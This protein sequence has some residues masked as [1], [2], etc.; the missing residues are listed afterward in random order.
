[1]MMSKKISL[2]IQ[3]LIRNKRVRVFAIINTILTI[4]NL[5][6][7]IG[8]MVIL[9]FL[10]FEAV[11]VSKRS[12]QD[13]PCIF[14]WTEWSPC[15]A[16]CATSDKPPMKT[17]SVNQSSIIQARGSIYKPCPKDLASR[18][19]FAPCN[20]HRCPIK[21]SSI[22]EWTQ[23]FREDVT[24]QNTKCYQM[25]NLTIGDYLVEIDIPDL[26]KDCDCRNAVN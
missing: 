17:R 19:D 23:C 5:I 11:E 7:F 4:L 18:K 12:Q 24:N 1:M 6:L 16:T 2:R 14:Q 21:L 8:C 9:G 22:N 25:R 26:T 10:I 20:T 3:P 13:K 15:P